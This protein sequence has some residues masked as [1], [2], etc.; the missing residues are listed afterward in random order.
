M[1]NGDLGPDTREQEVVC[2]WSLGNGDL[3]PDT[4]EQEVVC[5]KYGVEYGK[6]GMGN[7]KDQRI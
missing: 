3:G 7:D 4:R 1:G 2:E 6:W 5:G